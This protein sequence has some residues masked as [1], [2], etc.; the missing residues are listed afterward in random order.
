M[1]R[2]D[3]VTEH[4]QL[5]IAANSQQIVYFIVLL[6][7]TRLPGQ[8]AQGCYVPGIMVAILEYRN[9]GKPKYN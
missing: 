6:P 8:A 7:A 9:T 5:S 3:N 2:P 1:W 4:V